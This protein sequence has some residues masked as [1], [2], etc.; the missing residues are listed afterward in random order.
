MKEVAIT[1]LV[2]DKISG[3]W[4]VEPSNGSA[5]KVLRTTNFTNEGRL[6]LESVVEREIEKSLIERKHLKFGDTI[7]EK[8]GGGP[9]QPVGRVVFYDIKS[10]ERYL[11]NNFTAIL[12]PNEK[13]FP[14]YFFYALFF[15]HLSQGTLRYQNKTTGILN[16]KLE[17]Y[18]EE[19]KI[20]LPDL[21]IQ[22]KIASILE[23]ADAARQKRKQANQLTEQFLQSVF[24][25]MFGDPV[26]NEKGLVI[27]ELKDV[28]R[29]DDKVNYGVVQPG[30]DVANGV[31]LIRVGDF[32]GMKIS[33]E[34]L[35]RIAPEIESQYKRSRIV[36]DEIFVACV[37]SIGKVALADE[38]LKRI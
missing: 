6:N 14:K 31:P 36:G 10:D 9:K 13:V 33:K 2:A 25:E 29:K 37:G 35:K 38:S 3:E 28:V 11:S 12:R 17:R 19:E 23:Q 27:S 30:D 16:L 22:Q 20:K 26:R 7:I 15:K 18:L 34:N 8:S 5:T 24:I 21:K 32:N 4:G 1:D